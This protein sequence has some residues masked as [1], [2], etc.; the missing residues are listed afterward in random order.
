MRWRFTLREGVTF[1][2][3]DPFNSEAVVH[4]I[5]QAIDPDFD[6]WFRY[7][8]G[9]VLGP[10]EAVDEY[11]VDITTEVEAPLLPNLLTV[12]DMM[13][14]NVSLEEQNSDPV[15]TGP[16]QF[17]SYQLNDRLVVDRFDD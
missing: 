8:T 2:N 12:V 16:Y 7:G 14:P 3:G 5:A 15:R 6:V 17:N 10:A 13:S 4:S 9:G 11:T 1:H